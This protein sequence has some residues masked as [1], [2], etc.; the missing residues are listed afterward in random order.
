MKTAAQSYESS[1]GIWVA[2]YQ[3][4]MPSTQ[5]NVPHLNPSHIGWYSIFLPQRDGRLSWL[6]WVAIYLNGLLVRRQSPMQLLTT[7]LQSIW[8]S[9][10]RPLDRKYNVLL[11]V[12]TK[13]DCRQRASYSIDIYNY[14]RRGSEK[15]AEQ[16]VDRIPK[17][18]SKFP[19]EE[20][21][22]A[23]NF[24]LPRNFPKNV[25]FSTQRKFCIFGRKF[26]W[27][28]EIRNWPHCLSGPDATEY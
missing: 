5:E 25:G 1:P 26:F 18:R 27:K 2:K 8:K 3:F 19:T 6:W 17:D 7:W 11:A 23:Q 22:V 20:N 12:V 10:T 4:S 14:G 13:P 28:P 21:M 15:L 16:E 9:N 24:N